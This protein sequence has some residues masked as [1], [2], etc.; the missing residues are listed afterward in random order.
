[1]VSLHHAVIHLVELWRSITEGCCVWLSS[2]IYNIVM[3]TMFED[4]KYYLKCHIKVQLLGGDALCCPCPNRKLR[5]H[6]YFLFN[7]VHVVSIK[8]FHSVVAHI[9][10]TMCE[11]IIIC[12]SV[13]AS[14]RG[15]NIVWYNNSRI[16]GCSLDSSK[17]IIVCMCEYHS[18]W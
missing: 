10:S 15:Y 8:L 3:V 18:V 17:T 7:P 11:T 1:M 6:S 12:V 9:Y 4:D 16:E 13:A 5:S 14:V 2:N